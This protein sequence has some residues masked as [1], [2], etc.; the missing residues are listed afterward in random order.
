MM[1]LDLQFRPVDDDGEV[2]QV[3]MQKWEEG[4]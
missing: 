1:T 2:I 4:L 3:T